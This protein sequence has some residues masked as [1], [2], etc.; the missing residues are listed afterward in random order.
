MS[1]PPKETNVILIIHNVSYK[2]T[3]EFAFT[4]ITDDGDTMNGTIEEIPAVD[5]NTSYSCSINSSVNLTSEV[6]E[7]NQTAE[8]IIP[9]IQVQVFSFST[10][11]EFDTGKKY[12]L[13]KVK[14]KVC[15]K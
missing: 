2:H 13:C 5:W 1:T 10:P 9:S 8:I 12:H 3:F 15:I 4:L 14:I 6:E 7:T 11:G